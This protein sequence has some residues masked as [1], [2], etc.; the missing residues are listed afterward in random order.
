M[1]T[2]KVHPVRPTTDLEK[3]VFIYL[4]MVRDSGITNMFGAGPYVE[5]EFS[6]TKRE[7]VALL[8]SWMNNFN[9]DGDYENII[10]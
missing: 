3:R 5:R 8:S 10:V 1:T 4:N 6:V 9:E 2:S 7:A